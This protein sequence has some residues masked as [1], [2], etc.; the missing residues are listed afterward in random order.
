MENKIK[1]TIAR[2]QERTDNRQV[3]TVVLSNFNPTE[4]KDFHCIACGKIV[5]NYYSDVRLV[6]I[7]EV[8]EMSN[9]KSPIDIFCSRCGLCHRVI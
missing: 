2:I 5:F 8:G 7:G 4:L 9:M 3:V 1:V 6:I